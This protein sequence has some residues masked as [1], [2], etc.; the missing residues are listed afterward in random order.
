[1]MKKKKS[2]AFLECI[3]LVSLIAFKAEAKSPGP[4]NIVA[5]LGIMANQLDSGQ[6]PHLSTN[7]VTTTKVGGAVMAEAFFKEWF[8]I[9]VDFIFG[10]YQYVRESSSSLISETVQRVHVPVIFNFNFLK[11]FAFGLG[12][13]ASYRN[14]E[15]KRQTDPTLQENDRTSANDTGEHG[16]EAAVRFDIPIAKESLYFLSFDFRQSYSLTPR[17]DEER[18]HRAFLFFIKKII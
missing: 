4:G 11:Y 10:D 12:P 15:V 17:R 8:S 1:M 9:R 3:L 16:L 2:K 5:G 18:N 13:Y 6:S 7:P 14:G